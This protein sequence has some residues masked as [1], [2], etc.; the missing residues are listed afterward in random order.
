MLPLIAAAAAAPPP[1][2]DLD[3]VDAWEDAAFALTRPAGRCWDF[4]GALAAELALYQPTSV[5]S[6]GGSESVT[7]QGT[8]SGRLE[9]G[10]WTSFSYALTSA[11]GDLTMDLPIMPLV[12]EIDPAIVVNLLAEPDESVEKPEGTGISIGQK[13]GTAEEPGSRTVSI[14][15]GGGDAEET[16]SLLRDSI[17][18]WF[19]SAVTTSFMRWDDARHGA[20]LVIEVP[21]ADTWTAPTLTATA[22]FPGGGKVATELD[23]ILPRRLTIGEW[24]LR[25]KIMDGQ[26]HLRG[27]VVDGLLLPT[28]ESWSAM[29]GV[30]GFTGGYEQRMV[31]LSATECL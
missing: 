17:H 3:D 29:L 4:T 6:R 16:V 14:S 13:S 31:Y 22:F 27:Q 28:Q 18:T 23:S 19:D 30:V 2:L 26:L 12:G 8:F 24:P 25:A 21:T 1:S 9:D 20:Q 10:V 15:M 5:F 11:S 7:G